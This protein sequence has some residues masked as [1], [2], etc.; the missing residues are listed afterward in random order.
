M[1]TNRHAVNTLQT[2]RTVGQQLK[3]K[4]KTGVSIESYWTMRLLAGANHPSFHGS[5]VFTP[6]GGRKAHAPSGTT[7]GSRVKSGVSVH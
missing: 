7:S 4:V 2:L 5:D 1:G 6:A 3:L